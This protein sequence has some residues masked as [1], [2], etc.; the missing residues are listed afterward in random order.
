MGELFLGIISFSIVAAAIVFIWVLIDLKGA[1]KDIRQ[2]LETTQSTLRTT[3]E[4]L[5]RNL[6]NMNNLMENINV[7]T[8]NLK[9]VSNSARAVGEN[10]KKISGDVKDT[11]EVIKGIPATASVKMAALKAGI[12]T[13]AVVFLK[14]MIWGVEAKKETQ[15]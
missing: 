6:K 7:V 9:E 12:R 10:I 13:G 2:V 15:G 5:N 4:D 11:V 14:N 1:I 3:T 8:D